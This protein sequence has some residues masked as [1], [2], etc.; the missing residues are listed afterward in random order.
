MV[1]STVPTTCASARGTHADARRK[2]S[3]DGE[4]RGVFAGDQQT[5]LLNKLLQMLQA[6]IAKSRANVGS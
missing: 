3:V 6:V 4:L 5:A 1:L 2:S